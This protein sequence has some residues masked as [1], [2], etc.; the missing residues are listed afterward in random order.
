MSADHNCIYSEYKIYV[1]KYWK[2]KQ[3]F[4]KVRLENKKTKREI[5][6]LQKELD[7]AYDKIDEMALTKIDEMALNKMDEIALTKID[8]M[9]LTKM[10][11]MALTKIDEIALTKIDEIALKKMDEDEDIDKYE[12]I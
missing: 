12:F 8:E 2:I 5:T 1:E 10:D 7:K 6:R 9:A 4:S 3:M 11:E